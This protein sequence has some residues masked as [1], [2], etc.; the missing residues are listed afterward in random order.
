MKNNAKWM[1]VGAGVMSLVLS[2]CQT[3]PEPGSPEAKAM[4][5]EE[6]VAMVKQTSQDMPWWFLAPPQYEGYLSATGTATSADLQLALDKAILFAKRD[7]A[8]RINSSVSSKMKSFV[9]E[10]TAGNSTELVSE[11]ERITRNLVSEV[12]LSGYSRE[13]VEVKPQGTDYRAY[14]LLNYAVDKANRL[15][16]DQVNKSKLLETRLRASDAFKELESDIE[17]SN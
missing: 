13:E 2:A 3:V 14:V 12:N 8:D 16:V 1:L 7:L 5:K 10:T 15:L 6:R 4:E 17:K 11:I 9:A